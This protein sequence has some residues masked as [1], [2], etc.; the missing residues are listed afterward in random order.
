MEDQSSGQ[1]TKDRFRAQDQG[2]DCGFC[3]FLTDDLERISDAA[4]HD[5]RVEQGNHGGLD[6]GQLGVFKQK[7]QDAG[8][9]TGYSELD[10][11]ELDAVHLGSVSFDEQDVNCENHRA[12]DSQQITFADSLLDISGRDAKEIETHKAEE[13]TDP[14]EQ[15]DLLFQE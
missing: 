1:Y 10:A 3:V 14:G 13:D 4:A 5:A 12:D 15:G 8:E 2:S 9:N 6:S 7:H 11:G